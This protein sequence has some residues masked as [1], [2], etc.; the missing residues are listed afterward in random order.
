MLR[1]LPQ[2]GNAVVPWCCCPNAQRCWGQQW[3]QATKLS[4][5]RT[6]TQ[7]TQRCSKESWILLLPPT[8]WHKI[9][10]FS[11]CVR[12][13]CLFLKRCSGAKA[14]TERSIA[15]CPASPPLP[16]AIFPPPL[17]LWA[18]KQFVFACGRK[19]EILHGGYRRRSP[20]PC[21]WWHECRH[22]ITQCHQ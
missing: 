3:A 6:G 12:D 16:L 2:A 20:R 8:D 7:G 9:R 15:T 11:V 22:K 13:K 17:P 18:P 4:E 1:L 5:C 21:P 14:G 10:T 19:L